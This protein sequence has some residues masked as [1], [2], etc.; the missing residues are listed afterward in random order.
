MGW[1]GIASRVGPR[2]GC[3]RLV[4]RAPARIPNLPRRAATKTSRHPRPRVRG[5]TRRGADPDD[6]FAA[7]PMLGAKRW[8]ASCSCQKE[9]LVACQGF[10]PVYVCVLAHLI[11]YDCKRLGHMWS[12]RVNCYSK[13]F[14]PLACTRPESF[15]CHSCG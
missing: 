4:G 8:P 2:A 14:L 13:I 6:V 9:R 3:R 5:R 15:N 11:L 12:E 1:A 10:G 7:I